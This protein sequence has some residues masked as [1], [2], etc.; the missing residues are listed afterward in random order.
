M[1]T[2]NQ[3]N[4]LSTRVLEPFI[5]ISFKYALV[6]LAPTLKAHAQKKF[7]IL[8][9]HLDGWLG[10]ASDLSIVF[11]HIPPVVYAFCNLFRTFQNT[12][13]VLLFWHIQTDFAFSTML[14]FNAAGACFF[15]YKGRPER[16]LGYWCRSY[17]TPVKMRTKNNFR[18]R[19]EII[20]DASLD[21]VWPSSPSFGTLQAH[22]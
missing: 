8:D 3:A 11:A 18:S 22:W 12:L 9:W 20:E 10:G 2:L 13:R 17:R 5:K 14:F 7:G 4:N 6:V 15:I 1:Y 16:L 21:R 19:S